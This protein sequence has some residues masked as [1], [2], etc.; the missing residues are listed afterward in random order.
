MDSFWVFCQEVLKLKLE[1]KPHLEMV[2][3]LE[4]GLQPN[5]MMLVPRDC[6]KTTIGSTAYPLWLVLRAYFSDGNPC[7]R[8][9][10]DSATVR[11]SKFVIMNIKSW[12]KNHDGLKDAFGELY[13]RKGDSAE[14]LS[15]A[16]RVNAASAVKEPNFVASGVGAEKTGLHFDMIAMDDVVTKDNVRTVNMR[17]KTWEHYRMMQAILESDD[18][19]QKTRL[20]IVGTRYSDDD[21]YGRMLIQDKERIAESKPPIFAPMVRAAIDEEGELFYP[22]K[23]TRDVLAQRRSVMVGLFWAQYMNDPNKDSAPLKPE[24]LKWKSISEFP[25]E[26][27][28]IRLSA[29]PAYKED[30]KIHGDYSALVVAGWDRWNQ[31]HILDVAMRRDLTPGAFIDLVFFMSKKWQVESALIENPHQEAMDILFRREMQERAFSFPI[32]WVKPSRVRGKEMRWLDIQAYAERFA[33]KIATEI[34]AEVKVE[35]EDE[36]ARAPFSRFDDFLDALQLQTLYL[37]IDL[38]GVSTDGTPR[39]IDGIIEAGR[40]GS[41]SPYYGRLIDRFPFIAQ[42][43][44]PEKA[45]WEEDQIAKQLEETF[46]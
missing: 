3:Y 4:D 6:L 22:A 5:K 43:E 25:R 24:Q 40:S 41:D 27:K 33:I 38:K 28:W 18:S 7:Y 12:V 2:E 9:L 10:I 15:L 46:N 16:F 35:I 14:G 20:L 34:P 19:G 31:I 26:L 1:E 42:P 37:P 23:L 45:I 36:W 13:N 30:Q 21:L 32:F 8:V 17:E 29:D 39:D 11:L 44:K